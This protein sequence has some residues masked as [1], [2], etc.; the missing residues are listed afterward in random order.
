M[1]KVAAAIFNDLKASIKAF[2]EDNAPRLASSIAFATMFA[3]APLLIVLIAI[4]GLII[5]GQN[6]G[7]GQHAIEDALINQISASAGAQAGTMVRDMVT[8][9]FSRPRSGMIAQI[10][11]W[12]AFLFAAS[13]LFATLQGA[14]NSVWHVERTKGGWVQMFRG[15]IVSFGMILV[16]VFLSIVSFGANAFLT[17]LSNHYIANIPL[18]GSPVILEV[19]NA[20]LSVAVIGVIFASL[21]NV[22]P[23]VSIR[24]RDVWAGGIA[25]AILF[26]VGQVLISLYIAKAAVASAYGAAG[27]VLVV[28]LWV[29]YSA[30]IFLF[31]AELT[32]VQAHGAKT[33]VPSV[34][35]QNVEVPAG[36]DPRLPPRSG[37]ALQ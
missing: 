30:M 9:E 4:V 29:Y 32:K 24:W 8:A 27:S 14:L 37:S 25:T 23:D 6:S 7:H 13:G 35:K 31:G 34:V 26:V 11:G 3:L 5:G 18:L 16:L 10:V 1:T 2:S 22:L 20:V 19:V 17:Y 33:E 15:R 28:L 21:Y 12:F 36:V